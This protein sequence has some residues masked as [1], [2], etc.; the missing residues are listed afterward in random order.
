M[1]NRLEYIR[2]RLNELHQCRDGEVCEKKPCNISAI[3]VIEKS[4]LIDATEDMIFGSLNF[5]ELIDQTKKVETFYNHSDNRYQKIR[6]AMFLSRIYNYYLPNQ[7]ELIN[8]G[9]IP[10]DT[11]TSIENQQFDKALEI[12]SQS[13]FNPGKASEAHM[14]AKGLAYW[15][16][17]FNLIEEQVQSCICARIPKL[18]TLKSLDEYTLKNPSYY[19]DHIEHVLMPVRIEHTSCVG[20]DIFYLSMDRPKKARCI[21]ISANLYNPETGEMEPPINVIVRPVKEAGI[22]LTSTDLGCSKLITDMNDLFNMRNDDLSLLKAAVIVSGIVPPACKGRED[23]IPLLELLEKFM[24][25]NREYKGF[26][27]V[28]K[29][30]DIPRGSG[31]AVSTNLLAALILA[32]LRFS[33]QVEYESSDIEEKVKMEA[34]VR[35]IYGEWLGGSGGGWQD[36][37]GMW[38]GFKK[39]TGQAADPRY[40]PDSKGSLLPY[41]EE[42]IIPD[43]TVE[44][45]MDSLVLVNGGTGQDVGPI[46]RMITEQYILKDKVAW[47]ARLGTEGRFDEIL[48]ALLSGD[49]RSMARL[50]SMDFEERK[51]ISPLS[52]NLYHEK[53]YFKIKQYFNEDLWGYDSTGGR[54]GAGG[55]FFVDPK[56]RK[57]FEEIFLEVSNKTQKELIGQMHFASKPLIYRYEINKRGAKV[58]VYGK[59]RAEEIIEKWT[60]KTSKKDTTASDSYLT[61]EKIKEDCSFDTAEFQSIQKQYIKGELSIEKNIRAQSDEIKQIEINKPDSNVIMMPSIETQDYK[62]LFNEGLELL[63]EPL[64][65]IILNGGESTRFGVRT[66]RGLSPVFFISGKYC[67]SIEL[68]MRHIHFM[69]HH[70]NSTIYPVLV[71]SFFTNENTMRVLKQNNFYNVP[72]ENVFSCMHQVSHR[73]NPKV[74]DLTYWFNVLRERGLTEIEEDLSLQCFEFMKKWTK[75]KGEGK[76]YEP[77]GKNKLYTLVSPGHFYSFMSIISSYTLGSL[78]ERGVKRLFVASNDNLLAT[79]DPAILAFHKSQDRGVTSEVVPRLFDKG[80]A[81][82]SIDGKVVILEDFCFPDQQTLWKVPF[83]NP[84]TT[85]IE[86]DKLLKLT[87]LEPE[88]LVDAAHGNRDRQKRCKD[89]VYELSKRIPS[90]AVLKHIMEDMGNGVNYSFPVIQFEKLYGDL[91]GLM[92]P[93]F[94]VV[95]KLLRHTQ[96]KSVD[97][98]YQ[99]LIDRSLDILRPQIILD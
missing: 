99:I 75:E 2:N 21:N 29:V 60:F 91:I 84:I 96:M 32:L 41:Y 25:E 59:D 69:N 48:E 56:R 27:V 38:G 70:Y 24:R 28:S 23:E 6:S 18:F 73:V 46:L 55:I 50:E 63:K 72:E 9:T 89:A 97:H 95:P 42:L 17:A 93:V 98:I 81:P 77:I 66:I 44:K 39:I 8:I 19:A 67:S 47:K 94:L 31:L 61:V 54:A 68:K 3:D 74:E 16:K 5:D 49:V 43:S 33:G 82:V 34:A 35:C 80:G 58:R 11:I 40:D 37:G 71:N 53:T 36:Y 87:G 20:S 4:D 86:V 62:Y 45:I 7:S 1:Y 78:I 76:V 65:F 79:I 12:L 22:R 85:W 10:Y 30:I 92:N 88:D 51:L 14:K 13:T 90:Y 52:N 15:G 57:E 26:E 64:A 83:F